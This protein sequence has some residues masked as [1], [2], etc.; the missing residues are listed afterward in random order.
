MFSSRLVL[1]ITLLAL[2][3]GC[4]PAPAPLIGDVQARRPGPSTE[5]RPRNSLDVLYALSAP[6]RINARLESTDGRLWSIHDGVER[7]RAGTYVLGLD[8]TVPGPGPNE[9]RALPDG[10]Y[11]LALEAVDGPRRQRVTVTVPVRDADTDAPVIDDLSLLP[12]RVTPNADAVDDVLYLSYR[13]SKSARVAVFADRVHEDGLRTRAWAGEEQRLQ[14]GEQ[15]LT[16]D[17]TV[18]DRPLPDGAY[19]IAVRA[20]DTAGNVTEVRQ[21]LAVEAGGLAQAKIVRARVTPRQVIRGNQVCLEYTVRNTGS[22]ALRSLGPGPDYVYDSRDSFSAIDNHVHEE[23]PGF[24]RIGLEVGGS[25]ATAGARYPYRWGFGQDLA[26]DEE[27]EGRGC[28]RVHN[29]APNLVFFGALIQEELAI[30]DAGAGLAEV[31]LSS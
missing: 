15:R 10:E 24:W 8:G 18:G 13:L 20:R 22:A 2:L 19:E 23:R 21:P 5:P 3:G 11:L 17:A 31:R 1:S 6:V 12:S 14:P 27:F 4:A 25:P 26:P 7:P 9:R 30:H 28:V 16:W 29:T